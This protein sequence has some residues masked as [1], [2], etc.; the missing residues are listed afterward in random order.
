MDIKELAWDGM[1]TAV[2]AE[3]FDMAADGITITDERKQTVV[4]SD[5][6]IT[7]EPQMLIKKGENKDS[8]RWMSL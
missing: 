7:V 5:G 4:S 3:Q 6:Y 1:I 8:Q 2:A